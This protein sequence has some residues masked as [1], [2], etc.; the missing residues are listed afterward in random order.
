VEVKS[1]D[2]IKMIS[3]YD[4]PDYIVICVNDTE[5]I[6]QCHS[7]RNIFGEEIVSMSVSVIIDRLIK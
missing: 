2:G 3:N 4:K 5:Y 1:K 6:V 7:N